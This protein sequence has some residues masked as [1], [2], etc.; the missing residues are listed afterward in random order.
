MQTK[1][2]STFV[3]PPTDNKTT[4]MILN[5]NSHTDGITL[6]NQHQVT[7]DNTIL[8]NTKINSSVDL[9]FF[10]SDHGSLL[11]ENMHFDRELVLNISEDFEI[12]RNLEKDQ[13]DSH[14]YLNSEEKFLD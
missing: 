5:I 2:K 11:R 9:P 13:N 1:N 8:R 4:H 12:K 6:L 7:K 3:Y 14:F 10:E